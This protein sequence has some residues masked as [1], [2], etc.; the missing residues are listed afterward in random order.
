M[1][2]VCAVNQ[3]FFRFGIQYF[4]WFAL[5]LLLL[6]FPKHIAIGQRWWKSGILAMYARRR[7]SR[8]ILQSRDLSAL[9]LLVVSIFQSLVGGTSVKFLYIK[10]RSEVRNLKTNY[11][12]KDAA[13]LAKSR[14][15]WFHYRFDAIFLMYIWADNAWCI[16]T[17]IGH[18][19]LKYTNLWWNAA[20][21]QLISEL[22][23]VE[24][25]RVTPVTS[26][27][28]KLFSRIHVFL[29]P[30]I[31]SNNVSSHESNFHIWHSNWLNCFFLQI[32]F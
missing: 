21:H 12:P 18:C 31:Q 25:F 13:A 23:N 29:G 10:S 20:S 15:N 16:K 30:I 14:I 2:C 27:K 3:F 5:L 4:D 8:L 28:W 19:R 7:R 17:H 32:E 22:A 26:L 9:V 1:R 6:P 11:T 24:I